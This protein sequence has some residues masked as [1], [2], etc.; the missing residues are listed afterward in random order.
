MDSAISLS[1]AAFIVLSSGHSCSSAEKG[2]S[3]S[4]FRWHHVREKGQGIVSAGGS[5]FVEASLSPGVPRHHWAGHGRGSKSFATVIQSVQLPPL[6]PHD[7]GPTGVGLGAHSDWET[8]LWEVLTVMSRDVPVSIH[9]LVKLWAIWM[10]GPP[11]VV[12]RY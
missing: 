1:Y 12:L 4:S 5:T 3:W 11:F 9:L 10:Q 2:K 8:H 7:V 6:M